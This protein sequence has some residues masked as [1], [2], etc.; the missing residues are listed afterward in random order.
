MHWMNMLRCGVLL[1]LVLVAFGCKHRRVDLPTAPVSGRVTYQ[2]KPLAFGRIA[3]IHSSGQAAGAKITAD[4]S[5]TLA[6]FQGDNRIAIECFDYDK[7]GSTK[8]R[9]RML[10]DNK[11]LIP[12]RYMNYGTSGLTFEV[13]PDDNKAEFT[14]ND[15]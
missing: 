10:D 7:P 13:K 9:S 4:G 1:I 5:F 6:A 11:S 8:K 12:D 14:L 3:F 15:W 2:G